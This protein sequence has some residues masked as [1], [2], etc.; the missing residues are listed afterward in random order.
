MSFIQSCLILFFKVDF[1]L[2][3][4]VNFETSLLDEVDQLLDSLSVLGEFS[5]EVE[6]LLVDLGLL[7]QQLV[8]FEG[9][10]ADVLLFLS[11]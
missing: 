9:N 7:G 10:F 11:A 5:F 4:S 2:P 6:E 8:D 1:V 3:F